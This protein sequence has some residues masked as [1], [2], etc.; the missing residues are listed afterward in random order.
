MD[1]VDVTSVDT[2]LLGH[3][4][5]GESG[6]V[7]SDFVE[8]LHDAKPADKRTWLRPEFLGSDKYWVFQR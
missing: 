5:Y 7:L 4:Y 3:S 6:S 1:T 2:S 8:V